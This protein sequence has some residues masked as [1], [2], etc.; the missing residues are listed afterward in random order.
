MIGFIPISGASLG[1]G[2]N[3]ENL[4]AIEVQRI[5]KICSDGG[6]A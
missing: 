5:R 1:V 3:Q 6:F 2:V 4:T